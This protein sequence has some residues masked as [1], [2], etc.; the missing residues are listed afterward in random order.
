M[1]DKF[2]T[3]SFVDLALDPWGKVSEKLFIVSIR[4]KMLYLLLFYGRIVGGCNNNKVNGHISSV[5]EILKICLGFGLNISTFY[6]G[7]KVGYIL[8]V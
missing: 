8:T 1:Q 6:G 7:W 2:F 3:W 4:Y 5:G